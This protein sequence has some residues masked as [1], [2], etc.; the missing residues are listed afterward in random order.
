[1]KL[2]IL[3]MASAAV[4]GTAEAQEFPDRAIT[5]IAPFAAG[6]SS[7][8]LARAIARGMEDAL[9]KPVI[10]QNLP[11]AGGTIGMTELATSEPDGYTVA[12]GGVGS[13]IHSAEVYR[14][15]IQFDVSKDIAPISLLAATP[16]VVVTGPGGDIDTLD[17]LISAARSKP[18]EFPYGSSGM[19]TAMHLTAELFQ[20]QTQTEL[21]HIP[22]AGVAPAVT[23]LLGGQIPLGFFDVTSVL[24]HRENPDIHVLAVASPER[25]PQ[26]PDTPTLTESGIPVNGEIWYG[27]VAPTGIPAEVLDSLEA[28]AITAT[29]AEAFS[30]SMS[31]LGFYALPTGHAE[32]QAVMKRDSE[33]WLPIIEQEGIA[34]Q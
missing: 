5:L 31:Q 19:G 32:M 20:S 25:V 15:M 10:V 14:N 2:R 29:K 12:L 13:L 16:V 34:A 24:P 28:A 3:L 1:M 9:G 21:L 33:V 8:T 17:G 7:D 30:T 6:G 23:D 26:F 27:L 4:T 18:G 11:G 22:Y